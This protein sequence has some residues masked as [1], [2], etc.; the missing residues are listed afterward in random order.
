[1]KITKGTVFEKTLDFY[2]GQIGQ[3]DRTVMGERL[4]LKKVQGPR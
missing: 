1:M 2:P 4:G 3:A